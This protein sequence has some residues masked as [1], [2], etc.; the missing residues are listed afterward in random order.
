MKVESVF[1][2][3]QESRKKR[4]PKYFYWLIRISLGL[5]FIGS[6]IRKLPGIKFTALPV[7]NPVGAFFQAMYETGFYWNTI[8]VIQIG[9]GL[10]VFFNRTVVMT[11]LIMMPITINIFLVSVA[12]HMKGTPFITA[13]ML[14]ANIFLLLWHYENYL[15]LIQKPKYKLK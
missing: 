9:L 12:L 3:I 13:S 11:S 8:G 7:R 14:M 15:P 6:G 4:F 2:F 5:T 10:L 1:S